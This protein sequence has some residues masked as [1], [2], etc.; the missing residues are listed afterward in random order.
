[1][2]KLNKLL[3]EYQCLATKLRRRG[4]WFDHQIAT[5][6]VFSN[7]RTYDWQ[8]PTKNENENL[9]PAVHDN[10][11][12]SHG[13]FPETTIN[14]LTGG[15]VEIYVMS[16]E[17]YRILIE[18]FTRA[19]KISWKIIAIA[20][21]RKSRVECH[22]FLQLF[23]YH[24]FECESYVKRGKQMCRSRSHSAPNNNV[25]PRERDHYENKRKSFPT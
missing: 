23:A 20:S 16:T 21:S 1:M 18:F 13:V 7:N 6:R 2:K 8:Q 4:L 3:F 12:C 22:N 9:L 15:Q 5:L 25:N 24:R 19:M 17:I 10:F 14:P 11:S